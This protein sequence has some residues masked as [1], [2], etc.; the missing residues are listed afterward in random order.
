MRN[1]SRF[2][3]GP[4]GHSAGEFAAKRRSLL[5]LVMEQARTFS[6]PLASQA[7]V[8]V[9]SGPGAQLELRDSQV[10]RR[11]LKL[12]V[13]PGD[14]VQVES[15]ERS[16][17]AFINDVQLS[18][19]SRVRVG[20]MI[21]LGQS[22]L[23]LLASTIVPARYHLQMLPRWQFEDAVA[24]EWRRARSHQRCFSVCVMR[25]AARRM[26]QREELLASIGRH[27]GDLAILGELGP[28]YVEL[29]C[30]EVFRPECL[31]LTARL[32]PALG[33][34]NEGFAIG[35]ASF[36]EDGNTT[37]AVVQ[38]ALARLWGRDPH[39]L[40]TPEELLFLD[41]AMVRLSSLV[42]QIAKGGAPVLFRGEPGVGKS[43]LARALHHYSPRRDGPF[44]RFSS[45]DRDAENEQGAL[46]AS[47]GA[48]LLVSQIDTL[49][50]PLQAKLSRVLQN[51]EHP[52]SGARCIGTQDESLVDEGQRTMGLQSGFPWVIPVPALRDRPSEILPLADLFLA[53][54]QKLLG[55]RQLTLSHQV[56]SAFT[57]YR[58]P[59]NLRELKNVVER[60]ALASVAD[61]ITG[62]AIPLRIM[63]PSGTGKDLV[64]RP[65]GGLRVTLRAAEKEVLLKT[66][67]YTHWNVTQAAK[68]LGLPR[69]T[70]IYR[71]SKL[72]LRRP[73]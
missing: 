33:A 19:P 65:H 64:A 4:A 42:E 9:G 56:Q 51:A 25:L 7:E 22:H 61:E 39:R 24:A 1:P 13:M 37:D 5:L 12:R 45:A 67:A 72:G 59:G 14:W 60:A 3:S 32:A 28:E 36:P 11:Q 69:R 62:E 6:F 30:P 8:I 31:E 57:D 54:C 20:D 58:W 18:V 23:L 43:A 63:R 48:T 73:S 17:R 71:M 29:L 10:A 38:S 15:L 2:D 66:L 21:S 68:R 35:Y 27:V 50:P 47:P 41:P 26:Y 16:S 46:F 52:P 55:R 40:A 70:V 49:P 34:V 53:R 44:L